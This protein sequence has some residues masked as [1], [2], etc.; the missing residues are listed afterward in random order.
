MG[1]FAHRNVQFVRSDNA[2]LWIAKFPPELMSDSDD[3]H[4]ILRLR[5]I[6]DGVDY[7]CGC[8]KQNDYDQNR[9][10]GPRQ[11]NLVASVHLGRLATVISWA[12]AEFHDRIEQ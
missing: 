12:L 6:L 10:H 1:N 9:N 5:H 7:P 8:E 2:Y 3:F 11:F 4:S